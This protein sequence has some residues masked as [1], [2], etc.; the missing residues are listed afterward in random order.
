MTLENELINLEKKKNSLQKKDKDLIIS[1]FDDTIF[2]RTEQL[3]HSKDLRENRW[4]AWD[5]VVL[6]IIWIEKYGELYY[7]NKK[8]N[9]II[10]SKLRLWHDVIITAWN[11]KIQ[12]VKLTHTWLI[13]H[14]YIVVDDSFKKIYET[15]N[16]VINSLWFIPNKITVFEDRPNHFIKHKKLIEDFL[17]TKLE[18]ML[19]EM[20]WNED[21]PKIT[22]I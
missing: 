17:W 13:N 9:N 1:D 21:N 2:S 3:H 16:Y 7:K 4:R 15:I 12:K 11:E 8:Y 18:I 5:K 20:N 22:K 14:N 19:V 6:E 10:S